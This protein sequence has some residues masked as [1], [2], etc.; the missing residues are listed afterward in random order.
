MQTAGT[1]KIDFQ[2]LH[3]NTSGLSKIEETFLFSLFKLYAVN[4]K[5]RVGA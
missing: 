3:Q 5:D 4:K 2:L 1:L